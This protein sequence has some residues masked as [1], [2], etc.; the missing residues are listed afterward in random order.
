MPLPGVIAIDGPAGSGKSTVSYLVAERLNYLFIDTG[1]FYRAMTLM[2]LRTGTDLN[3]IEALTE[4]TCQTV[5]DI[6]PEPNDPDRQYSVWIAGDDVTAAL[7]SEDVDAN[8]SKVA[9]VSSVRQALLPLQRRIAAQGK[10]IM[11][12][13][14]IG[15]VV[16]PDADIK[17]YVDASLKE[18]ARRRQ[19]QKQQ[20]GEEVPLSEIEEGLRQRDQV[21]TQRE[22]SPLRQAD[23]AIYILTDGMS[24]EAVVDAIMECVK[25][26][27]V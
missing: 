27:S 14:D 9:A 26:H 7:R 25:A 13:R 5:V 16:L 22:V 3:D 18:R 6:K 20:Q 24:I 15:T 1:V 19:L 2:A 21:D 17:F 11:A 12:G 8:V 10:L 23:D 4:L